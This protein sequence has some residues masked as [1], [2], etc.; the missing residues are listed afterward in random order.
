MK[1]LGHILTF[2]SYKGGVGRSMG[3]A[4][5]AALLAKWGQKVL[6]VDWDLEAPGIEA[7]FN[8]ANPQISESR[9]STPGIIDLVKAV[10]A[11]Q[12]LDWHDC[13]LAAS[14][15]D[16]GE[17]INIISAGRD[18]ERYLPNV[19]HTNWDE[20]FET[21]A[22]G[23]YIEGLRDS[24]KKE[25]D[26]VLLD[27]RTGITDIGGVCTIHLPDYLLVW[28]TTNR[29]S[30]DGVRR[31][32][33]SA[34]LAQDNLPFDR[35][36]LLILPVP[37]RDESR[38]EVEL[39]DIWKN[40]IAR[41]FGDFY[42]EWLPLKVSPEDVIGKLRIPY[43]PFWSFG[44]RLP[45]VE[46][47]TVDTQSIG[48]AYET[49]SRLIF[50]HFDWG[51]IEKDPEHS[52]EFLK[53]AMKVNPRRFGPDYAN[54]LYENALELWKEEHPDE[55]INLARE[56]A[57]IW[58]KILD[59]NFDAYGPKL[60]SARTFLSD[61]LSKEQDVLGSIFEANEAVNI[62]QRLYESNPIDFVEDL[63][64]SLTTHWKRV[65][66]SGDVEKTIETLKR[67]TGTQ[68]RL[69]MS[70]PMPIE[71]DL[72][73]GLFNLSNLLID[74]NQ[75][76]EA[77]TAAEQAVKVYRRLVIVNRKR[78]EPD[79]ANSLNTLS[80][81]VSNIGD[82][83]AALA[84]TKEAVE[85]FKSLSL[86]EPGR[87]EGD[88]AASINTFLDA[89]PQANIDDMPDFF[90]FFQEA[91]DI[92]R[93]LAI[94][95]PKRYEPDLAKNLNILPDLVLEKA[96]LQRDH[97]HEAYAAQQEATAIFRR[98]TASNPSLY[99][100]ELARSLFSLSKLSKKEDLAAAQS[101]AD[102]ASLIFKRLSQDNSTRYSEELDE[103]SRLRNELDIPR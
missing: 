57:G 87:Y 9:K 18:D 65:S 23:L 48:L 61:C 73:D 49:L 41:D 16:E 38:T 60:A 39:S 59:D 2:Y 36:P 69:A 93:A 22:L 6:V 79:L 21:K 88:V 56:A 82:M 90:M 97:L 45:V 91:I 94:K 72:A 67:A 34:R 15:F 53:R 42:R 19:Q 1:A 64:T 85:I 3:L 100:V 4:N 70:T 13:L 35:N 47:G 75:F 51:G 96:D 62:Y 12:E 24:W 55:S 29:T 86:R 40:D 83:N 58:Q 92:F 20:L 11:G 17:E 30:M 103:V 81:C 46:K 84:A 26:F 8:I 95:D 63:S 33:E 28:F 25:F 78:Y 74:V 80:E 37:A 101:A 50:F 71:P 31:V 14:P 68:Q 99:E 98:L 89:I 7:Y 44:E 32:A 77:L 52:I 76:S 102:E 5:V 54:I 43:I 66:E 10:E 27:S